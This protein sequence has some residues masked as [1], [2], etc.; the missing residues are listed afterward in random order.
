MSSKQFETRKMIL[1][2][3]QENPTLKPYKLAKQLKLP[4]STVYKVIN[5]FKRTLS[6]ERKAGSGRKKGFADKNLEKL[7]VRSLKQ[8]PE[9]SDNDRA[10]KYKTSRCTVLRIRRNHNFKSYRAQKAPNRPLKQQKDVKLRAQKLYDEI[11]TTNDGCLMMDDETYVK[12]DYKQLPG[13]KFYTAIKRGNV[14]SKYKYVYM[15]KFGK[16]LMVWQALCSCAKKSKV[17]VTDQTMTS[18]L[19]KNECLKNSF[20]L[21]LSHIKSQLLFG[22]ISHRVTIKDPL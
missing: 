13:Q 12:M 7:I 10:L 2:K 5:R 16:K 14:A 20:C 17:F 8:H 4:S 19:Y 21:L 1:Y 3:Y 15:D 18:E 22:P 9:L 11:L 6:I